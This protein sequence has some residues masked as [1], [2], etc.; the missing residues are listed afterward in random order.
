MGLSG[1]EGVFFGS[2]TDVVVLL[3]LGGKTPAP[4]PE[5]SHLRKKRTSSGRSSGRSMVR[6]WASRKLY[7][8]QLEGQDDEF[9]MWWLPEAKAARKKAEALVRSFSCTKKD[10]GSVSLDGEL[11]PPTLNSTGGVLKGEMS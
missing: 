10:T 11:A 3:G 4:K 8:E 9:L 7:L 6:V 5:Y 2:F 1:E